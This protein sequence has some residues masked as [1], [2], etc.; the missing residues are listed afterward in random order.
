[1]I[2]KILTMN[3]TDESTWDGFVSSID[4]S[5][6]FHSYAWLKFAS[7]LNNVEKNN[8]F[9]CLN[10][11]D[12]PLCVCPLMLYLNNDNKYELSSASDPLGVPA[13]SDLSPSNRRK[14]SQE[15]FNKIFDFGKENQVIKINM[16]WYPLNIA[17]CNGNLLSYQNSFELIKYNML[18]R[19]ENIVVIDLE[20]SK[21]ELSTRMSK[22][23]RRHVNRSIKKGVSVK[24]FNKKNNND[25]LD[26]LIN[27]FKNA[28][29]ISAGIQTRSDSTWDYTLNMCKEGKGTLFVSFL[30]N[31]PISFL[32]CGEFLNT[33]YGF[34]QVNVEKYE[35]KFSPRHHL[36]WEAFL[37]YKKE[38]F[39]YYE[40]GDRPFGFQL[41]NNPSKKEI[42]IGLFKERYGGNIL[43]KIY[44]TKYLDKEFMKKDISTFSN[45]FI[46]SIQ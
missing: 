4:E 6:Y 44:W 39:K 8:S 18:Y 31:N 33:A 12:E 35:S 42:S 21:D 25:Q 38:G 37:Y 1:M 3:E 13:I 43:H 26:D 36:E 45:N 28:H 34:S 19:I 20:R 27:Q 41:L 32:F 2:N 40:I 9:L 30:N 22:Y 11:N 5:N 46:N 7:M 16:I 14:L 17:I 29:L 15:I 23:Q 24:I 10:D